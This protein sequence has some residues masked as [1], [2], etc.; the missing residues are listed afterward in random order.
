MGRK[1]MQLMHSQVLFTEEKVLS[2]QHYEAKNK[3]RVVWETIQN[4][5]GEEER[6]PVL[7]FGLHMI[8]AVVP[9]LPHSQCQVDQYQRS[10]T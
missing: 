3:R 5:D 4:R 10:H 8:E 6:R 1:R 9:T 7:Q 2:Y